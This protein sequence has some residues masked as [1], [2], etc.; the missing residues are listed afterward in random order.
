MSQPPSELDKLISRASADIARLL[1]EAHDIGREEVA[2]EMMAL[3][4][5]LRNAAAPIGPLYDTSASEGPVTRTKAPPG[6]VKPAIL[7]LIEQ[8]LGVTTEQIIS[9]T[10]FKENS[11]RGTLSTLA[12]EGRIRRSFNQWFVKTNK[13]PDGEAPTE[14]SKS[15]DAGGSQPLFRETADHDR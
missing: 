10:G 3:L 13:A 14:A 11:V 15:S 7:A 2:K 1:K 6:T 8:S 12:K 4:S 9:T 5:P